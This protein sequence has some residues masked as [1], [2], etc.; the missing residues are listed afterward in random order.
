MKKSLQVIKKQ[1]VLG[2]EFK[3]YGTIEE[4]LFLAKDVANWIEHSNTSKMLNTVD[5]DEKILMP[6]DVTNSYSTS[7]ARKNQDMWFLTEHGLYEVLMQSKKP[8]AKAF[9]KEV[10]NILTALRKGEIA[11]TPQ[12]SENDMLWLKAKKRNG[13]NLEDVELLVNNEIAI[14]KEQAKETIKKIVKGEDKE[15]SLTEIAKIVGEYFSFELVS[16]DITNFLVEHEYLFGRKFYKKNN[17]YE[18]EKNKHYNPTQ[19]FIDEI[20]NKGFAITK[21][22]D[23][24]GKIGITYHNIF[25]NW[26]ISKH[27]RDLIK[28]I[29]ED[30]KTYK[31][32]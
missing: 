17:P 14:I 6:C 1:E 16:T 30:K 4:P 5:E 24:R 26:L 12:L 15:S 19:K 3:I 28:F 27:E 32:F 31:R 9:K 25:V 29:F 2:K 22:A 23:E 7:R 13:L 20:A 11:L 18:K 10:K 21:P 8:I